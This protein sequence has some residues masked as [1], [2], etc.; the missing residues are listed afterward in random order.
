MKLSDDQLNVVHDA[1]NDLVNDKMHHYPSEYSE[2][3]K[4]AAYA[5]LNEVLAE[6]KQ[7]GF[8]WAR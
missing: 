5:A 8:W 6:C 7:R 1:L 4:E 2:G 3:E